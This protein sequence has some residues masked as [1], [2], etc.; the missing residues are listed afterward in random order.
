MKIIQSNDLYNEL[1]NLGVNG[2]SGEGCNMGLRIDTDVS[3]EAT[4]L[5]EEFLGGVVLTHSGFNGWAKDPE[6]K[7]HA[8]QSMAWDYDNKCQR[9]GWT[10]DRGKC[11]KLPYSMAQDLLVFLL[12]KK[13]YDMV[14]TST[15]A[16]KDLYYVYASVVAM[17]HDEYKDFRDGMEMEEYPAAGDYAAR[18]GAHL[19]KRI[20][21]F[22]IGWRTFNNPNSNMH[23]WSGKNIS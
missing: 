6:G 9:E 2:L 19:A 21:T 12:L 10:T 1:R 13:G 3:P 22:N 23:M 5:V 20:E 16:A 8:S 4:P 15:G 17:S 11:F 14:V 18:E 7:W